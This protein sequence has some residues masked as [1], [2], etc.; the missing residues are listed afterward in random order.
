MN[1]F[2]KTNTEEYF[3]NKYKR[4]NEKEKQILFTRLIENMSSK[5]NNTLEEFDEIDIS[6][7]HLENAFTNKKYYLAMKP[8][9]IQEKQVLYY[10]AIKSYPL[11]RI[12]AVMNLSKNEVLKLKEKAIADFKRNLK[13]ICKGEN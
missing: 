6:A 10:S 3:D 12:S 11:Q 5:Q 2:E 13:K 4:E 9:P 1:N 7:E 8:L